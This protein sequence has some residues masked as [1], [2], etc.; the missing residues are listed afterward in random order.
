MAAQNLST[1]PWQE[2]GLAK[3]DLGCSIILLDAPPSVTALEAFGGI[4]LCLWVS[5]WV[6]WFL[7][8]WTPSVACLGALGAAGAPSLGSL[9]H[10]H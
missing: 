3:Q 6:E 9:S 5:P 4:Y 8:G 1:R 2:M 10:S 7:V